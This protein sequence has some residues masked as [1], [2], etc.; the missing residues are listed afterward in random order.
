M[1]AELH[2]ELLKKVM[3]NG[4]R[5]T[6]KEIQTMIEPKVRAAFPEISPAKWTSSRVFRRLTGFRVSILGTM[7]VENRFHQ[8]VPL[9]LWL[10]HGTG[11]RSTKGNV[12]QIGR[13]PRKAHSTGRITAAHA[14]QDAGSMVSD[15]A[16]DK[17]ILAEFEKAADKI[18]RK[19]GIQ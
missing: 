11:P 3:R 6:A 17:I 9:L 4:M 14:I 5:R 8:K 12:T 19:Y 7:M 18:L 13:R 2:P 15:D 16:I 10:E 1:A